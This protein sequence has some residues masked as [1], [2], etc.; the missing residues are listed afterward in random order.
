MSEIGSKPFAEPSG[1]FFGGILREAGEDD[2]FEFAGLFGD[3]GGDAGI[4]VAV[5]IDP[6]GG[7]GVDNFAAVGGVEV[8][9]FSAGDAD[10]R[11]VEE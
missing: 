6:P 2:V 3:G 8:D 11:R 9:A 7:D 4:G 10:R 1:E 5:K